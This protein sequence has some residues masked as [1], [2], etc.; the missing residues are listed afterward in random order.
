VRSIDAEFGDRNSALSERRHNDE[1]TN[2]LLGGDT[3]RHDAMNIYEADPGPVQ[4]NPVPQ[5]VTI[6]MAIVEA[7]LPSTDV[8][9]AQSES[10]DPPPQD[11]GRGL[12]VPI[13]TVSTKAESPVSRM[14]HVSGVESEDEG[15]V[16]DSYEPPVAE[17]D[18]GPASTAA[19]PPFSPAPADGV[20]HFEASD[21][22]PQ[23]TKS[24]SPV[25]EQISAGADVTLTNAVDVSPREVPSL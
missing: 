18:S 20:V 17:D 21:S 2:P 22:D 8:D 15:E 25:P 10:G 9:K 24:M 13:P 14:H 12:S 4:D 6:A 16:S 3:R 5:N 23:A 19:S 11:S 7:A 1:A